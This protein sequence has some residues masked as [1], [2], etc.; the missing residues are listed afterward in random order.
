MSSIVTIQDYKS[1]S[2]TVNNMRTPLPKQIEVTDSE[3]PD[4]EYETAMRRCVN[5]LKSASNKIRTIE[6]ENEI[7]K[8]KLDAKNKMV[9]HLKEFSKKIS[10]ENHNLKSRVET[11]EQ[12]NQQNKKFTE[13][14]DPLEELL[15]IKSNKNKKNIYDKVLSEEMSSIEKEM[16]QIKRSCGY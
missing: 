13:M 11:F 5:L 12:R 16:E 1:K 4:N 8:A 2:P 7:N 15:T 9:E 14:I 3:S 6:E 10:M